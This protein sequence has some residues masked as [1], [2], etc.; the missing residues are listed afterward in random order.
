MERHNPRPC[1]TGTWDNERI[2]RAVGQ[3]QAASG[4]FGRILGAVRAVGTCNTQVLLAALKWTLRPQIKSPFE[5]GLL[6]R[7]LYVVKKR[8][9][10]LGT[11][12][13]STGTLLRYQL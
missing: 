12:F 11:C 1:S 9:I 8:L 6:Q 3:D 7:I 2:G 4:Y 5:V 13:A 10:Y